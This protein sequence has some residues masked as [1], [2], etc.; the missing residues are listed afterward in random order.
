MASVEL[1][2]LTTAEW[3]TVSPVATQAELDAAVISGGGTSEASAAQAK[4]ASDTG[5]RLSPRRF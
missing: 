1:S 5:T 2:A 3:A 4:A